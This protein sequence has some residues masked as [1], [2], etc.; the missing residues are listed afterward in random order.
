MLHNKIFEI[1]IYYL[2]DYNREIYGREIV[3][4]TKLSQKNIALTLE[5]LE[6][7]NILKSRKS[8]NIKYYRLNIDNTEIKDVLLLIETLNK[9][10]FFTKYR[11]IANLF[12]KD[13]RIVGIFGSY[14]KEMQKKESDVDVFIIGN[15]IKKDYDKLG[16]AFDMDISIKYFSKEEFK[17][18]MRNKNNLFKEIFKNHLLIFGVEKFIDLVWSDYYGFD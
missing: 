14:A 7:D 3:N 10:K 9:I 5:K 17:K 12:K 13:D 18:L 15:K 8:G 2:G 1:L 11:K 16:N 4:K 6:K